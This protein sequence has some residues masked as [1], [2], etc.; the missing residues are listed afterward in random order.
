MNKGV[1]MRRGVQARPEA[2]VPAAPS[3]EIAIGV[4]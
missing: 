4:S 3:R 1:S 2:L